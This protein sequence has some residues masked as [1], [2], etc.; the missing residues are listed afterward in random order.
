MER[1]CLFF[2]SVASGFVIRITSSEKNQILQGTGPI[3]IPVTFG[4]DLIEFARG[5]KMSTKVSGDKRASL[6]SLVSN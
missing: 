4:E 1:I 2:D 5:S 3:W 6:P